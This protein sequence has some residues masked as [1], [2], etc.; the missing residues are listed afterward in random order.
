MLKS[1]HFSGRYA[2]FSQPMRE[3]RRNSAGRQPDF[4][5]PGSTQCIGFYT[6]IVAVDGIHQTI[7]ADVDIDFIS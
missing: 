1:S 3:C 4:G 7:G 2:G 5:I 6:G